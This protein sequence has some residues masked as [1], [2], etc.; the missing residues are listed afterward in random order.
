LF[1]IFYFFSYNLTI[2]NRSMDWNFS[3]LL[4]LQPTSNII[5]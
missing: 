4:I 5:H 1:I 3:F 2:N